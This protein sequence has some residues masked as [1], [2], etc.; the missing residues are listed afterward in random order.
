MTEKKD[1]IRN[2]SIVCFGRRL[3]FWLSVSREL[4]PLVCSSILFSVSFVGFRNTICLLFLLHQL[5]CHLFPVLVTTESYFSAETFDWFQITFSLTFVSDFKNLFSK[6]RLKR[7]AG[8]E[9]RGE[10]IAEM[11]NITNI[12]S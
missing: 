4:S 11:K 10:N 9:Y 8:L 3:F 12:I 6:S 2:S 7:V 1:T 5:F